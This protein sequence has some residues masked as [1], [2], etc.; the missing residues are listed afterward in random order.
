MLKE[1]AELAT[2]EIAAA[3][4]RKAAQAA[5]SLLAGLCL[6]AAAFYALGGLHTLLAA[7]W[8]E[9]PASF[10]MALGLFVAALLFWLVALIMRRRRAASSQLAAFALAAAPLAASLLGPA[11]RRSVK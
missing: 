3:V 6:L 8:G 5:L 9:A 7:S 4:R 10:L 2:S 11:L 1:L